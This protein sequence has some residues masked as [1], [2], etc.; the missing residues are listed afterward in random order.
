M[1]SS[2]EWTPVKSRKNSTHGRNKLESKYSLMARKSTG[3]NKR[4][5]RTVF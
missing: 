3:A 4:F 2:S 1:A 5:S